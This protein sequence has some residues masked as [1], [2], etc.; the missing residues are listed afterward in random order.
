MKQA[1]ISQLGSY[2]NPVSKPSYQGSDSS[3][4]YMVEDYFTIW[5]LTNDFTSPD[6]GPLMTVV[7]KAAFDGSVKLTIFLGSTE[8]NKSIHMR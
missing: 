3:P 7:T 8:L 1:S 5:D 2:G 6:Y 4:F